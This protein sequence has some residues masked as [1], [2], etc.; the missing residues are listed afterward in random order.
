ML[1][2]GAVNV[3]VQRVRGATVTAELRKVYAEVYELE[4]DSGW[5]VKDKRGKWLALDKQGKVVV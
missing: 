2:P 3:H 1:G 5:L 4:R